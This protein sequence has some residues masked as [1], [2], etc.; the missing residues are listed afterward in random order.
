MCAADEDLKPLGIWKMVASLIG[1][2]HGICANVAAL[3]ASR[4]LVVA[5]RGFRSDSELFRHGQLHYFFEFSIRFRLK[6]G[7]KHRGKNLPEM[8]N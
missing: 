6:C 7:C 2:V 4:P 1:V 8:S 3:H 5:P